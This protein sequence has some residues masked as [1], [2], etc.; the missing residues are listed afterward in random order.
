MAV[1]VQKESSGQVAR[2]TRWPM[3]FFSS[4]LATS[5]TAHQYTH[6]PGEEKLH[7][8]AYSEKTCRYRH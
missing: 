6:Q 4:L 8:P 3:P 5:N 1:I 7:V 2:W